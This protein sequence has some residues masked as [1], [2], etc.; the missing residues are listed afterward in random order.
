VVGEAQPT[1]GVEE[2]AGIHGQRTYAGVVGRGV[3]AKIE[4][5]KAPSLVVVPS[6]PSP[7]A[8]QGFRI[9]K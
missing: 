6:Q 7:E 4:K 9:R 5:G 1:Q 2:G 8:S 3:Q